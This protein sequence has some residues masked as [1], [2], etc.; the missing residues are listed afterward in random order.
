MNKSFP[1]LDPRIPRDAKIRTPIARGIRHSL[2]E[3]AL[4]C[5][6][7][8]M[9]GRSPACIRCELLPG[10]GPAREPRML[11]PSPAFARRR[12]PTWP[13][14][15]RKFTRPSHLGF[16]IAPI[17]LFSRPGSDA[18]VGSIPIARSTPRQRQAMQGY[19]IG[20]NTLI[21]W[22]STGNTRRFGGL[23]HILRYPYVAPAFTRTVTRGG[24][25]T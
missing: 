12:I 4:H 11:S 10:T 9:N 24:S 22:E 15:P 2:S 7:H 20:V 25:Q 8:Q 1:Y 5:P 21:L 3:F 14:I 16:A 17:R 23:L 19:K 18:R 13:H 6:P